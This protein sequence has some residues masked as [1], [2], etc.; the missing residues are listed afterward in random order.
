[1]RLAFGL[2]VRLM[3]LALELIKVFRLCKQIEVDVVA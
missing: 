2:A 3:C 1:M